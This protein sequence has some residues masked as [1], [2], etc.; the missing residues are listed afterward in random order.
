MAY[1]SGGSH[2]SVAVKICLMA[3]MQAITLADA[4]FELIFLRPNRPSQVHLTIISH[5]ASAHLFQ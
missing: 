5:V 3:V 1:A 4:T 2:L